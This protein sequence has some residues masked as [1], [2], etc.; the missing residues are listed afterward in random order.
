M[1][2]T[3]HQRADITQKIADRK[4]PLPLSKQLFTSLPKEK[5]IRDFEAEKRKKSQLLR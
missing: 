4:D 5:E 3:S 2:L 1:P